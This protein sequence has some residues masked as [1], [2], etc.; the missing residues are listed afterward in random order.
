MQ[1]SVALRFDWCVE[2]PGKLERSNDE[3]IGYFFLMRFCDS[4]MAWER[5]PLLRAD[6]PAVGAAAPELS[7]TSTRYADEFEELQGKWVVYISIR[8][9]SRR[10]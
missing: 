1:G 9:T 10:L 7:L 8:R 6:L 2:W 5:I 3:T 4:G